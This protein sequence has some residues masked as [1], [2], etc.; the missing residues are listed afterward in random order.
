MIVGLVWVVFDQGIAGADVAYIA[1]PMTVLTGLLMVSKISYYSFKDIDPRNKV[2]FM[3]ML[4]IVMIFVL[5]SIDPPKVLF[6]GFLLYALSGPTLAL[7]RIRRK[8][9]GNTEPGP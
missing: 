7:L 8:R 3:A 5:A 9:A 4:I 2:P 1:L 6:G